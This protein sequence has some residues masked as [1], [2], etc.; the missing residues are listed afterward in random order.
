MRSGSNI[1]KPNYRV[2]P[3]RIECYSI[4]F[5]REGTLVFEYEGESTLLNAGDLFCMYP[6]RTYLYYKKPDEQTL[7]LSWLAMDGPEME[8]ILITAG[9]RQNKP[10]LINR[11][12]SKLQEQ[13]TGIMDMLRQN[14]SGSQSVS[15]G[16]RGLLFG[17]LGQLIK[18]GEE[19]PVYPEKSWVSKSTDHIRLHATE[20]I[21]VQQVAQFAGV[22]RT[23]F[24]TEFSKAVGI[25]PAQYIAQVKM[26]KAQAMLRES[27]A[28]VTE[29]AYS[30]GYTSLYSFTR[31]FKTY[32][33]MSPSEYRNKY[34]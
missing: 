31:A 21:T 11:W 9:L 6:G 15:F 7:R 23:Y 32:C 10:Y 14:G 13:V 27:S 34:K 2:G 12:N 18:S 24:S 26:D 28:T 1:A 30:I 33:L 22:N 17:L 5:V 20:G 16:L 8:E 4:H 3:R 29:I 19:L 25:S